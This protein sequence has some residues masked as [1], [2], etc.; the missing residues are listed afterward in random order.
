[1]ADR[2]GRRA[3]PRPTR[4]GRTEK[5]SSASRVAPRARPCAPA[6]E[7]SRTRVPAPVPIRR[8]NPIFRSVGI[9]GGG[10]RSAGGAGRSLLGLRD[11]LGGRRV[12]PRRGE[13][14]AWRRRLGHPA[15]YTRAPCSALHSALG[16]P[17]RRLFRTGRGCVHAL[18]N[19]GAVGGR[20]HCRS[21][22]GLTNAV[23]C[24][25]AYAYG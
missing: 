25:L 10:L 14:S 16:G 17:R 11:C 7:A 21:P 4:L 5:A 24:S 23:I 6:S 2:A 13:A 19:C 18:F 22:E 20:F 3:Q 1:M 8:A 9:S 15:V 12:G